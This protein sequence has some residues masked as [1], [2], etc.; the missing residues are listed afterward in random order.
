MGGFGKRGDGFV[1]SLEREEVRARC[2]PY[3]VEAFLA[4]S[5]KCIVSSSRLDQSRLWGWV[6][7]LNSPGETL[8]IREDSVELSIYVV[9]RSVRPLFLKKGGVSSRSHR[10]VA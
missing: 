1:S 6:S 2:S 8:R 4:F 7:P 10:P 3:V 5:M 9:S